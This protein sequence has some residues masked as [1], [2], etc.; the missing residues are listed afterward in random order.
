MTFT[1]PEQV[2]GTHL[3][4]LSLQQKE[5][6]LEKLTHIQYSKSVMQKYNRKLRASFLQWLKYET[7]SLGIYEEQYVEYKSLSYYKQ[8]VAQNMPTTKT[9]LETHRL[10]FKFSQRKGYKFEVEKC[11]RTLEIPVWHF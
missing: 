10:M 4:Q 1:R 2:T 8:D 3:S 6:K 7:K 9:P 11:N 5:E